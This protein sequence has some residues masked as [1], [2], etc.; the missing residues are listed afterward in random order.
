MYHLAVPQIGEILVY[1]WNL[2]QVR[3]LNTVRQL[4]FPRLLCLPIEELPAAVA[5]PGLALRLPPLPTAASLAI[6]LTF[7]TTTLRS[8]PLLQHRGAWRQLASAHR[9]LNVQFI[10]M[11]LNDSQ[12]LL[13]EALETL[14]QVGG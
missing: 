7:R 2:P 9:R 12:H 3:L 14:P 5:H 6:R 10:H 1:L 11:V 8:P 13:H 4:V